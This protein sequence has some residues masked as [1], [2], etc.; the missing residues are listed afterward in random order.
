MV[1]IVIRSA[2]YSDI[3]EIEALLERA[4]EEETNG[5]PLLPA[6][7]PFAYQALLDLI[8]MG[9]SWIA[10][11]EE[12]IVGALICEPHR[13]WYRRKPHYIQAIAFYIAPEYRA[14]GTA[15]RLLAKLKDRASKANVPVILSVTAGGDRAEIKDRYVEREGFKYVGGN[16]I[17]VP[18]IASPQEQ[19]AV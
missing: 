7:Q 4:R 10:I 1:K 13:H 8:M 2:V 15:T 3:F 9:L 11:A 5:E 14:G 16:L 6:E 12:G 17:F 18:E 19:E